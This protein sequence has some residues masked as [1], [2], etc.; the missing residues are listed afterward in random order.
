MKYSGLVIGIPKEILPGERRVSATP[1]T[2]SVLVQQG[3]TVLVETGAGA[4]AFFSD[5][6]YAE[7]GAKLMGDVREIFAQA[8]LI[9]KVKEPQ[10][11]AEYEVHEADL[12]REDRR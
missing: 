1:A 12:L 2:V 9:L 6:A 10:Y 8:D 7:A 5:E 3:A 11:N 4:G